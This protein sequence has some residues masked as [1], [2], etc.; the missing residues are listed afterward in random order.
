M[1]T[2]VYKAQTMGRAF[3]NDWRAARAAEGL[4]AASITAVSTDPSHKHV[5][6]TIRAGLPRMTSPRSL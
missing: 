4:A 1:K 3:R 2:D 6:F 5:A